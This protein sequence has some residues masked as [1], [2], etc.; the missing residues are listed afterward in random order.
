MQSKSFFLKHS[1]FDLYQYLIH[2]KSIL[3]DLFEAKNHPFH[4]IQITSGNVRNTA[5]INIDFL[6]Q[7]LLSRI[8]HMLAFWLHSF[9]T[10]RTA[11]K[12]YQFLFQPHNFVLLSIGSAPSVFFFFVLFF[13]FFFNL[14]LSRHPYT[15]KPSNSQ[16]R[17]VIHHLFFLF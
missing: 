3:L 13:V 14:L 15:G 9:L 8:L 4:S 1:I 6:I 2:Y 12:I 11:R 10:L 17:E 16:I 7:D 5:T